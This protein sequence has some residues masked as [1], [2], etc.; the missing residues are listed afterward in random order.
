MDKEKIMN[1]LE[2]CQAYGECYDESCPYYRDAACLE[3]LRQD[4]LVLL[5]EQEEQIK[6]V[7]SH[8]KK[9]GKKSNGFGEC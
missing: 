6:N 4:V 2:R 3:K 1:A 8:S 9:H 5:K 7:M